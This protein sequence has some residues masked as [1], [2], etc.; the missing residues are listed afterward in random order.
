MNLRKLSLVALMPVA[1]TGCNEAIDTVK[2]ARMAINEQYTVDEA[3]SNRDICDSVDWEVVTDDRSRE[4]VQYTCHIADT[5]T[6]YE[7]EWQRQKDYLVKELESKQPPIKPFLDGARQELESTE[8]ALNKPI[9]TN[10]TPLESDRLAELQSLSEM[11]N[12]NPPSRALQNYSNTP[13]VKEV[14]ELS[15]RYHKGYVRDP[16]DRQFAAHKQNEEALLQAI[17]A[18]RPH[19][20]AAIEEERV[21]LAG[22][23][24]DR[25]SD[26]ADYALQRVSKAQEALEKLER[27]YETQ[28][29][30][31]ETE[32]VNKL[33]GFENA[34]TIESVTEV[35]QWVVKG[36]GIELVWSGLEGTYSDGKVRDFVHA[37][38]LGSLRDVYINA[39]K[40]YREMRQK[41]P[42]M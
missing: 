23:Q 27:Q 15:R 6:F 18:T 3:F 33:A 35:F 37:N 16:A 34:P 40:T 25:D 42:L 30:Q 38:R 36:D 17:A 19:V 5:E 28:L 8:R 20:Q 24:Q 9:P 32:R 11:L 22:V 41:A 10:R 29:A 4:L 21:R 2:S 26:S 31:L 7:N 12:E 1:L 13:I 14:A 39:I